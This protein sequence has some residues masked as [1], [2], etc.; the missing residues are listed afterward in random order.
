MCRHARFFGL[1][2]TLHMRAKPGAPKDAARSRNLV[3]E[4]SPIDRAIHRGASVPGA[5]FEPALP[6]E[7]GGLRSLNCVYASPYSPPNVP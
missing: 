7:K 1:R 5:G 6:F 2:R 4:C 3:A